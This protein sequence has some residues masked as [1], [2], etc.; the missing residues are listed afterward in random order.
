MACDACGEPEAL[1]D[2][3]NL[4]AKLVVGPAVE[5]N[6]VVAL[7]QCRRVS[8]DVIGADVAEGEID[9]SRPLA[10]VGGS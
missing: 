5:V 3:L 10:V 1:D 4:L 7:L 9:E 8:L 6:A 2:R